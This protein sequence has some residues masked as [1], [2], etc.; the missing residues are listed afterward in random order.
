[1]TNS[2]AQ[3]IPD[4]GSI[5]SPI[6]VSGCSGTTSSAEVSVNITHP[7]RGD[8]AID[9]VAP[10]GSVYRLK[11]ANSSDGADNIV[12]TFTAPVSAETRNGTWKLTVRDQYRSDTG[13][14]NSWSLK[15]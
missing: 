8:I 4:L 10:D 5:S 3:A 15:V 7:Y 9:L 2:T 6:T 12:Q 13:T 11:S 1:M 14:L